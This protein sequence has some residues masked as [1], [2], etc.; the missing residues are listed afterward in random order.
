[1]IRGSDVTVVIPTIAGREELLTRALR[2][3]NAQQVKPGAIIVHQDDERRGAYWARNQGLEK[4]DTDW[5]AWLDDDDELLPNHIKVLVRGANKSGADLIFSYPE[6]IGGPDPL[7]CHQNGF[8]VAEPINVPF[9]NE[10]EQTLRL[11]GNFIPI[12]YLVRTAAVRA[13][14]G[15]PNA[16]EF[17]ARYSRD[18]EDYGLLLKM[19]DNG[20]TFHHVCGVRT[21][22]YY[23]HEGNLG[24]RG[25]DRLQEM[26]VDKSAAY[27][28]SVEALANLY[29]AITG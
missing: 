26:E 29:R 12:T 1:M 22:R 24:G 23:F 8:L 19:L 15:F 2:S 13:V 7:A 16:W 14:G 10:A 6:F 27:T 9:H 5:V 17:E 18:C 21:W 11:N 20:A 25:L 4:V 28:P 3:V